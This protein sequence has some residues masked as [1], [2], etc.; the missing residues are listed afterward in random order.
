M[1]IILS[2]LTI[3]LYLAATSRLSVIQGNVTTAAFNHRLFI[4]LSV[5][6]IVLHTVLLYFTIHAAEG[7][8]SLG[9]FNALSMIGWLLAIFVLLATWLRGLDNLAI[10]LFPMA[11]IN[12]A[13]AGYFPSTRFMPEAMPIASPSTS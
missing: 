6:A 11:A 13:L 8:I 2:F 7:V 10:V 1:T 3:G 9:F 5:A 12:I 4:G